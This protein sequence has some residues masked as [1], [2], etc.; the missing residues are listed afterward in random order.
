VGLTTP[1]SRRSGPGKEVY[2]CIGS[3][4]ILLRTQAK[5]LSELE[6]EFIAAF[7][8]DTWRGYLKERNAAGLPLRPGLFALFAEALPGVPTVVGPHEE[9]VGEWRQLQNIGELF[10]GCRVTPMH[11]SWRAIA[12]AR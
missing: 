1:S 2:L 7:T 8:M 3:H 11:L 6:D 9:P 4:A 12:R 10:D 5:S